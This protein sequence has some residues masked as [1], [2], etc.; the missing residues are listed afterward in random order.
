MKPKEYKRYCKWLKRFEENITFKDIEFKRTEGG[1]EY[2]KFTVMPKDKRYKKRYFA[3]QNLWG[4]EFERF[5]GNCK[6]TA[7]GS[8]YYRLPKG[9]IGFSTG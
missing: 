8:F 3:F 1:F 6:H 2:V 9:H 5:L 4:E 7:A